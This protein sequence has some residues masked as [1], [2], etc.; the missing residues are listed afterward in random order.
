MNL[1]V[2]LVCGAALLAAGQKTKPTE[3]DKIAEG[4]VKLVLAVGQHDA[5]YVD[6]YYGPPAWKPADTDKQSLDTLTARAAALSAALERV[7]TPSEEM[8]RLRRKYLERQMSSLSARL[9]MLKGE[10]LSFDEESKALYDAVAPTLPESHFQQILAKLE[11]RFPGDGPLVT[12]VE[13]YRR[14]FV[15]PRPKLDQVF[16]AAIRACRE[17]TVKHITLPSDERFTV[18]YVTICS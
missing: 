3:M 13:T 4:Y 15:I 17:R 9:R 6:A 14:A 11:A 12:R 7:A 18:E 16:Q 8:A 1:F 5:D 2:I 10:R